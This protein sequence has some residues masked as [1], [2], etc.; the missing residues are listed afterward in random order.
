VIALVFHGDGVEVIGVGEVAHGA[1]RDVDLAV[2]VVVAILDDVFED[3][4]DFVGNSID[5]DFFTERGLAGKQLLLDVGAEDG[6]AAVGVF[7]EFGEEGTLFD[8][9]AAHVLI[10]GID[11]ADAVTAAAGAV[12]DGALL[13][14]FGR[15]ALEQ[16]HF[17]LQVVEVVDGELDFAAGF[18]AAGL[19]RGASGKTK[20]RFV[21][22]SGKR[23]RVR[24]RSRNRR[25]A[26]TRPWRCPRPCR[27]W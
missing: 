12:G 5:A 6:D 4:D 14:G 9:D 3:A 21:P 7:V 27:A 23:P 19:E 25:R 17:G 1:E 10:V 18:G 16:R 24:A 8:V 15:D 13:E 22:R 11:S 26:A 20:T 2:H